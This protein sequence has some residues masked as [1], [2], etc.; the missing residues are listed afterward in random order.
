MIAMKHSYQRYRQLYQSF[1][2]ERLMKQWLHGNLS[3]N[4][5]AALRVE[6]RHRGLD[7]TAE[8]SN[9]LELSDSVI[10]REVNRGSV[11][12]ALFRLLSIAVV[13]F[14]ISLILQG[15][16]CLG[17]ISDIDILITESLLSV[18]LGAAL[19]ASHLN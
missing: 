7:C 18:A 12:K 10:E 11:W 1:D 6:L 8:T 13:F 17:G 19:F 16:P 3:H 4:S 15:H 2:D 9:L 5:E 14:M